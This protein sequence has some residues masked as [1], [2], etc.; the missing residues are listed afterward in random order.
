MKSKSG[1]WR[2][3][4]YAVRA[5][6]AQEVPVTSAR[7]ADAVDIEVKVASAWLSL[8][9]K[10]G[11]IRQEGK[12]TVNG[13]WGHVWKLTRFGEEYRP[14]GRRAAKAEVPLLKVAANPGKKRG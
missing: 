6:V 13:R 5:L 4:L 7:L 14:Q 3:M 1:L 10:W 8:L 9:G 11:Y 2:E 12:E